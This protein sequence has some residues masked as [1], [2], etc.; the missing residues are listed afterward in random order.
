MD[1]Y[2][3]TKEGEI[4]TLKAEVKGAYKIL[5]GVRSDLTDLKEVYNL[6]YGLT[7][8]VSVLTEQMVQMNKQLD[9]I[10]KVQDDII[11]E[12]L[13]DYN[14]YRKLIVGGIITTTLG[15]I[16]GAIVMTVIK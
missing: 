11:K 3:C 8:N 2:K 16:V 12:P 5:D 15:A 1:N 6:I 9:N 13:N 4:A 10:R 14:H 7:T